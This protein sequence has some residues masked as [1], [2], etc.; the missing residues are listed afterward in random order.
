MGEGLRLLTSS[1]GTGAWM[2]ALAG[3]PIVFAQGQLG[4]VFRDP[5]VVWY[6][7]WFHLAYTTELCAGVPLRSFSCDWSKKDGSIRSRFG[8]ARSL[9]LVAWHNVS[10]V[11]VPLEGACNVWAPE[12][13]V[14]D[15]REAA[16]LGGR[17]MMAVFSSTVMPRGRRCPS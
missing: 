11:A 13:F 4:T 12:W 3:D 10:E 1:D 16:E 7:G 6:D 14:L 17:R 8:Y 2:P 9:D 15:E 5:S